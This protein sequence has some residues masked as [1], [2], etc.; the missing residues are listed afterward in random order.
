MKKKGSK[1]KAM[2]LKAAGYECFAVIAEEVHWQNC[3]ATILQT[4]LM[5]SLWRKH[6]ASIV[7]QTTNKAALP[8][9]GG[10]TALNSSKPEYDTHTL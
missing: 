4:A 6:L 7:S 1:K 10:A 9:D 5:Q 2:N 8:G 3:Q